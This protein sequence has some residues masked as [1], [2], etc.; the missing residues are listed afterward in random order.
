MTSDFTVLI[1][2]YKTGPAPAKAERHFASFEG[3]THVG[4]SRLVPPLG[5]IL[6]QGSASP[7]MDFEKHFVAAP[8]RSRPRTFC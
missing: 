8:K 5:P 1:Y 2:G 4:T 7:K 6:M 3:F